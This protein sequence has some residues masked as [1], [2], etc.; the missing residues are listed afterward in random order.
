MLR[1]ACVVG[2]AVAAFVFAAPAFG[3]QYEVNTSADTTNPA[4][5]CFPADQSPCSLRDAIQLANADASASTIGFKIGTGPQTIFLAAA[6]PQ[7]TLAANVTVDGTTQ[8]GWAG[9]PVISIDGSNLGS[10]DN[11]FGLRLGGSG[12]VVKGLNI[13]H[14][15]QSSFVGGLSLAGGSGTVI[16]NYIGTDASIQ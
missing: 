7:L 8:T 12:D 3:G 13:Q 1:L 11:V 4:S 14:F 9:P 6:Q 2:F 10:G 5:S 15:T 16:G